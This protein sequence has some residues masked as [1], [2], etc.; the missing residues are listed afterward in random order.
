[1][2]PSVNTRKNDLAKIHIAKKDLGLD[3]D[4]YREVIRAIGKAASGSSR[5]LDEAGRARVIRH[6]KSKGWKVRTSRMDNDVRKKRATP[7][8]EVLASDNQ[9]RMIR[10]L[11]IQ[12]AD[13]GAVQNRTEQGLRAWVRSVTRKHHPQRAGWSAPEFLPEDIGQK[14]I[15]HLKAWA[16]RCDVKL[17]E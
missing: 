16:K 2:N 9:V 13:A 10:S 8:G 7:D 12:M 14:V 4:T 17:S 6:F 5:D 15:E 11:W 3:D 1:M